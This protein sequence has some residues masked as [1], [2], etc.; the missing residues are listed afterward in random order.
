MIKLYGYIVVPAPA[1]AAVQSELPTHI[2]L[3]LAEPG[4]LHFEVEQSASNPYRFDVD[5]L[6]VDQ[7]AFDAHQAR[8]KASTWGAVT[9]EV[10]RH[11]T[12]E[13]V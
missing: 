11:Y 8:V 4:C 12:V 7:A 2:T 6:F 5:E 3:T 13:Q 10:E 9:T 1:L